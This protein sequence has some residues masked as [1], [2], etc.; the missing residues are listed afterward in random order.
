M[1]KIVR[2][3][4]F[5]Y[6][7]LLLSCCAIYGQ[8]TSEKESL[9]LILK[10]LENKHNIRF[11]YA[12]LDVNHVFVIPPQ[13]KLN[14]DQ[15]LNYIKNKTIFTFKKINNRYISI[16]I[17]K[18]NSVLCGTI[19]DAITGKP[20]EGASIFISEKKIIAITNNKGKFYFLKPNNKQNLNIN[21][22]GYEDLKVSSQ[23]LDQNCKTLSLFQK[24]SKLDQVTVNHFFTKG[25]TK[26]N[27]G[28]FVITTDEFG[29]VPGQTENDVFQ[30]IQA[31]PGVESIDESITN[32]N[33]RGG[34]QDENLILW[35]DIKMYQK[36]HF[37]GLISAFNPDLIKKVTVY[38]NGTHSRF[39]ES[40][41][42]IIDMKSNNT[43]AKTIK[44][45]LG[46]N[47][48]NASTYLDFPITK[49][50]GIQL[51]TRT[52]VNNLFETGIY[53]NYSNKIFQDTEIL[54]INVNNEDIEISAKENFNF[55][56]FSGKILWD[57]S[58]NGKIRVNFLTI[59]NNL[60]YKE[61]LNETEESKTSHLNQ[62][63]IA[64]GISW[65]HKWNDKLK[66]KILAYA[67][68]YKLNAL[69][70]DVFSEQEQKQNN[71]VLETGI[72]ID[73]DYQF[74][75]KFNLEMGYHFSEIGIKN[76]QDINTPNFFSSEKNILQTHMVFAQAKQHLFKSKTTV[77]GG[78]R[79]NYFTDFKA[80]VPEPRLSIHHNLGN[81][82]AMD[83]LAEFKSQTTTQRIDFQ[84]DFLG[85]IK[86]R[87]VLANEKETPIIKSKQ[88]SLG[89][90]YN[91]N[92]WLIGLEG[93]IK[94]VKGITT[95]NQGF[96][97][98][99]QFIKSIGNYQTEGAE[100]IVNKKTKHFSFW[101]SYVFM[102]NTYNF[103]ELTP[104]KFPNNLD[105]KQSG[106]LASS[107][108]LK[109]LKLALGVNWHRGKPYT[110][111][112]EG[113]E[114]INIEG[115]NVINYNSPN[116]QNLSDYLRVD[117]S[118]EY[119]L[120]IYKKI[121]LKINLA[122]LNLLDKKN[123]LNIRHSLNTN[124]F[125]ETRISQVE[126]VSLGFSPNFSLQ[127]LF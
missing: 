88:V 91:K 63:T 42:G 90:T 21:F 57:I 32:I 22:I 85:V 20:L 56:D 115:E 36:G 73:F 37:F 10:T 114:T 97:N 38:K 27:N 106:T 26:K 71:E 113:V 23:S 77:S 95:A 102:N 60:K 5:F 126:E 82:F 1:Q 75:D 44:A 92:N 31:L 84:S 35:D 29:L 59:N 86:R 79:L 105:I 121:D 58:E 43:I 118:A 28:T 108:S 25:I 100:F 101:L 24:A 119:M 7:L 41:S 103:K 70:Q 110:T 72:K 49:N 33:I 89:I 48:I 112:V 17:K 40:V 78:F 47:L 99:F 14:L 66:N 30:I 69:N 68:Y 45:G 98:Q 13:N 18:D 94:K 55:Y 51:S 127:F 65:S 107:F 124:E 123:T 67:S 34:T 117:F 46:I 109:K 39:G 2:N 61:T 120:K 50:I 64:S 52:S 104:S 111:P 19:I 125:G 87:W 116:S 8:N 11:S 54:S 16:Q 12:T 74:S 4:F 122:L 80:F 62:K 93:F 96:Q 83:A 81:G 53:N 3:S 6:F 15:S 9:S 76:T